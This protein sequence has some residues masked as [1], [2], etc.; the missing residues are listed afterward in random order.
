MKYYSYEEFEK[1]TKDLIAQMKNEKIDTILTLARGG[2]ILAQCLA[3]GL[4]IRDVQTIKVEAYDKDKKRDNVLI[5]STCKLEDNSTVLIVDDIVDSGDSLQAVLGFLS[6]NTTNIKFL[7][8]SIFYK[9][10]ACV[11]PDFKVKEAK[12]WIEF[13]WEKDFNTNPH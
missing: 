6:Q 5:S 8:A 12:E 7:S 11:Q 1:D 9:E 3:Y 13:F 2:M 10:N 4:D